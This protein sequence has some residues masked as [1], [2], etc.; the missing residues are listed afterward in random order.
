MPQ[1]NK[2]HCWILQHVPVPRVIASLTN[3]EAEQACIATATD[4]LLKD[5]CNLPY[6]RRLLT[7]LVARLQQHRIEP[8]DAIAD[9]LA[10][11]LPSPPT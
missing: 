8:T 6:A 1:S 4:H 3:L 5:P 7:E 2:Q 10:T 11:T 9:L